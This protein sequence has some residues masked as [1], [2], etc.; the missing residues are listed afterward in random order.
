MTPAWKRAA[1]WLFWIA[2]AASPLDLLQ[3]IPGLG[4]SLL[5]LIAIL[6]IPPLILDAIAQQKL[7]VP[8]EVL[9]P[10]FALLALIG[11]DAAQHGPGGTF[12]EMLSAIVLLI[13]VS[14][15]APSRDL[16]RRYVFAF[17]LSAF[18]V[19]LLTL[20]SRLIHL[21]PTAI[22]LRSGVTFTFSY[23]VTSG[24]HV[25]LLAVVAAL[26]V[27]RER[28][29]SPIERASATAA[30]V[31]LACALVG[32]ALFWALD[33]RAMPIAGYPPFSALQWA[34]V[35]VVVWLGARILGKIAVDRSIERD[36]LHTFWMTAAFVTLLVCACAPLPPAGYQGY[37]AG[38]ACASVLPPRFV[39]RPPRRIALLAAVPL[40]LAAANLAVVDP[41]NTRDHRQY[42]AASQRDFDAGWYDRLLTRLDTIEHHAPGERRTH[43]WR[44]RTA[45]VLDDPNWA[46][47]EYRES[48]TTP[49]RRLVLPPPTDAERKDFVVGM[50][51]AVAVLPETVSVCAFERTLLAEG[52]RDA[53]LYS[54][55]LETAVPLTHVESADTAPF[56]SAVT[57]VLGDP[58]IADELQL[59]SAEELVTLLLYWG[60]TLDDP[61]S[62]ATLV[63]VAQRTLDALDVLV[64]MDGR[65]E[66]FRRELPRLSASNM[67]AQ[68]AAGSMKWTRVPNSTVAETY[69]LSVGGD[70]SWREIA[71]LEIRADGVARFELSDSAGAIPFT[72]AIHLRIAP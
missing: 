50:R 56:A 43:L 18:A 29:F 32:A 51:D 60:A 12:G 47:F 33:T 15:F 39:E 70:A 65:P 61:P 35:A 63:L 41:G 28:R 25:L 6:L 68:L 69:R 13:A 58:A 37:L 34:S 67:D 1:G 71:T 64:F 23:T 49:A 36:G 16:V 42:D 11:A 27:A 8:F 66:L 21:F 9:A 38:L 22:S 20:V 52:D 57:H 46:S 55:R 3:Y 2:A 31:F 53:A 26:Y 10:A 24:V 5:S 72:P 45:L 19:T 30:I 44:A 4:I 40:V 7:R 14:H 59:W 48:I 17:M 54:L 62:W